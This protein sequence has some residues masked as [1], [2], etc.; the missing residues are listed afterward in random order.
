M[1]S[2]INGYHN[3]KHQMVNGQIVNSATETKSVK[4]HV[5]I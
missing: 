5:E 3:E 2:L 1:V 4:I